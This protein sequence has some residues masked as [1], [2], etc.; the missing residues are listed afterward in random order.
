ML[1]VHATFLGGILNLVGTGNGNT[2]LI[3]P[4]TAVNTVE[5][6]T[7]K[8]HGSD[9]TEVT[10]FP[11][12]TRIHYLG[13]NT[14]AGGDTFVNRTTIPGTLSFGKADNVVNT[15]APG[16][17]VLAGHGNNFVQDLAG[18]SVI[19]LGN[20]NNN[21]QGGAGDVI[22]VGSGFNIV[23]DIG[24]GNQVVNVA[25]HAGTDYL[26]VGPTTTLNGAQPN[27]RVARFFV[28]GRTIGSGTLVL[29]GTTLYYTASHAGDTYT[30]NESGNLIVVN[31]ITNGVAA[32]TTFLKSQVRLIANFGGAGADTFRNNTSI[33]DL[34]YGAGGQNVLVGGFGPLNLLKAGGAAGNSI[35]IGRSP[36]IND[37]SG[38]G[39]PGTS[40]ILV[41]NAAAVLNV[42][43]TNSAADLLVAR[44]ANDVLITLFPDLF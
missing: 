3:R 2:V 18:S 17:T 36:G 1:A 38:S 16:T 35:A 44:R 37:L 32:Q 22:T 31:T 26:F 24:P 6:V 34:Q 28:P 5:L 14:G 30:A 4:G 29:D 13:G 8:D 12:P 41:G 19:T 39:V 40:S 43:R 25:P 33:P 23:Y 10:T 21:V 9:R 27:D 11:T 7:G 20:G 15:A 42:F